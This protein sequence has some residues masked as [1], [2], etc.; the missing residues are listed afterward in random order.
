MRNSLRHARQ[1]TGIG[2]CPFLDFLAWLRIAAARLKMISGGTSSINSISRS[3]IHRR[4]ISIWQ[5]GH[6]AR[7]F[8]GRPRGRRGLP[9]IGIFPK[10]MLYPPVSLSSCWPVASFWQFAGTVAEVSLQSPSASTHAA[11]REGGW[12]HEPI[13]QPSAGV[14]FSITPTNHVMRCGLIASSLARMPHGNAA[15]FNAGF[16]AL[17]T[18][19]F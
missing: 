13:L 19:K 4:L 14:G 17:K 2:C 18:C 9:R 12:I 1:Q 6:W 11:A 8:L 3:R 5:C 7:D 16:M 15:S 10:A